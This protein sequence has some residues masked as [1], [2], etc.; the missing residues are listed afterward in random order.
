M[1]ACAP[2]RPET[3]WSGGLLEGVGWATLANWEGT[4]SPD[5]GAF[6]ALA[7]SVSESTINIKEIDDVYGEYKKIQT[8]KN[9]YSSVS[10]EH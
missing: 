4:D 10:R 5:H 3:G 9:T 7:Q 1:W 8:R 2:T 6:W